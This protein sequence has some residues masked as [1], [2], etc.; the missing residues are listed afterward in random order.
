MQRPCWWQLPQM[1]TLLQ[2]FP[3][4]I[5][6]ERTSEIVLALVRRSGETG[7]KP[8]DIADTLVKHNLIHK[9]S[10]AVYSYLSGFKKKGLVRLKSEGLYVASAK[11][12]ATT[13]TTPQKSRKKLRLSAEG[14]EAIR[15]AQK[16]RWAAKKAKS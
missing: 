12:M 10:N 3:T 9:G 16:A 4:S 11:P 5:S 1:A 7:A 14:I 15:K 13:G 8:R 2:C 6:K